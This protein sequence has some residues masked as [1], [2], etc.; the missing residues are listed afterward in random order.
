M[1]ENIQTKQTAEQVD[2]LYKER[3]SLLS[4]PV[5]DALDFILDSPQPT[6][7][8]HSFPE[9]DLYF[10]INEASIEDKLL[11]LSLAS[12]K[13]WEFI[14][15]IEGWEK[16]RLELASFTRWF[17]LFLRA[18][19]D[20]LVGGFFN[21]NIE[22]L[23][24]YLFKNIELII[25]EHDQ[26]P[27]DFGDDFFT[28][29]DV[30]YIRV[31]DYPSKYETDDKSRESQKEIIV[32]LLEQLAAHDH[33]RYQQI[34]IEASSVLSAEVEEEAYRMRNVRLAEKGFLPFDEAVGIYQPLSPSEL[35]GMGIKRETWDLERKLTAP[36]PIYP[37]RMLKEDNLFTRALN[38]IEAE[39]LR[40]QIQAEFA[41][42]C[43]QIISADSKKIR[44]RDQL[45]DIVKKACGYISIGLE[46]LAS[47]KNKL[48][49]ELDSSTIKKYPLS[50]IFR[51]G[52]GLV[53][54]LK[55]KAEK[56]QKNSWAGKNGLPLSF[57][58]E[59]WLGM[60]G[61]LLIQRPLYYDNYKTGVLYR[62]FLSLED[63]TVTEKGL[64]EIIA[65]DELLSLLPVTLKPLST[66][67]FLTYKNLV[68][69]LWARHCLD[70]SEELSAIPLNDFK[71]F[72]NDL[73]PV[74]DTQPAVS[75]SMKT[76]FLDWL[77]KVT[78]LSHYDITRKLGGVLENLFEELENEYSRISVK[79]LDPKY[80][81]HFLLE[82][83][84]CK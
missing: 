64:N 83:P 2:S 14:L 19:P 16:D 34:L 32:K 45:G 68:L 18:D 37:V 61:G 67:G 36:V 54:S 50:R 42:L 55:W 81:P 26:D 24:F 82:K 20:R 4:L 53:L 79:H 27:S 56:W 71:R 40:Q 72:F 38:E 15:D 77:S 80:I 73:W 9:E 58:D 11:L 21:E 35:E 41:G 13:Q 57:W 62:E 17:D 84:V 5:K 1:D 49:A 10:M 46:R 76:S 70:L 66:Y 28:L 60:L 3:K 63:I 59:E 6:A 8:V 69:T 47:K 31:I 23:E 78:G 22:L 7:L 74:D 43:N 12:D 33:V 65:F 52:Y 51:I 25:R 44:D 75:I 39:E 29:D 30:Y 48:H